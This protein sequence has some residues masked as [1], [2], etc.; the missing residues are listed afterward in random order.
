MK[1]QLIKYFGLALILGGCSYIG[2]LI[3]KKYS[4][5]VKEL[6][7]MKS[8]LNIFITKI[9][10][11][12]EPIPK[13]FEEISEKIKDNKNV[14]NIFEIA[15]KEMQNCEAGKAW[16][17]SLE[18]TNT[19]MKKQDIEVLKGLSK[20]LGKVDAEGQVREIE[21]VDNFLDRQI[22]EAEQ[23]RLKSEKMYRT[24]GISIGVAITVI[25]I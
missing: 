12:Y 25:L 21:L 6:K 23:E 7:E 5:R 9:K 22:E 3:S 10:Y 24:L 20:L 1:M 13:I 17:I 2:I 8:A 4:N 14:A 16:E 19:N 18:K 15:S 11:T